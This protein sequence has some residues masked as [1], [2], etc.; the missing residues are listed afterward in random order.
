MLFVPS[1]L[2]LHS[3]SCGVPSPSDLETESWELLA[4]FP[5]LERPWMVDGG[6]EG[7]FR[8]EWPVF[9]PP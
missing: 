5:S 7:G 6:G 1:P 9:Q 3:L 2:H 8:L 4:Y